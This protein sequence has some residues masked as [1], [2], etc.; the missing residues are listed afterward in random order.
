[1]QQHLSLFPCVSV[2]GW[3]RCYIYKDKCGN[4]EGRCKSAGRGALLTC[5][6]PVRSLS[7]W[8]IKSAPPYLRVLCQGE[9]ALH[10]EGVD[11]S[12]FTKAS[13]V[14]LLSGTIDCSLVRRALVFYIFW[15]Y[16][17]YLWGEEATESVWKGGWVN[18]WHHIQADQ[19]DFLLPVWPGSSKSRLLI[20]AT[21]A[22]CH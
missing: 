7:S 21:L 6:T 12:V 5:T 1:M 11:C 14:G 2:G 19:S 4:S 18:H 13:N 9:L 3:E 20:G 17:T 8:S 10:S 15:I 22:M 16:L